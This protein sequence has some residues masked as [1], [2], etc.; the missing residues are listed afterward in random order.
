MKKN[1]LFLWII[2]VVNINLLLRAEEIRTFTLNDCLEFALK[3]SP[4]LRLAQADANIASAERK[5]VE[6][7]RYPQLNLLSE[8][9]HYSYSSGPQ[10]IEIIPALPV[11]PEA[12]IRLYRMGSDNT[13]VGL[14]LGK[15]IFDGGML[16]ARIAYASNKEK[17][18]TFSLQSIQL[19]IVYKVK[20]AFYNV[21]KAKALLKVA[22]KFKQNGKK[23]YDMIETLYQQGIVPQTDIEN[24]KTNLNEAELKLLT[25]KNSLQQALNS[26][27]LIMGM[28]LSTPLDILVPEV[29]SILPL[30]LT[31]EEECI[32]RAFENRPKIKEAE[33]SIKQAELGIKLAEA[34]KFPQISANTGYVVHS[35][36][37]GGL[38]KFY[39]RLNFS[40]PL[41]DGGES[42]AQIQKSKSLLET[43]KIQLD[44]LKTQISMEVITSF[45]EVKLKQD[46]FFLYKEKLALA[47]ENLKIKQEKYKN[48]LSDIKDLEDAELALAQA[49]TEFNNSFYD[50]QIAIAKLEESIGGKIEVK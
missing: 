3:N 17:E 5:I 11:P 18:K 23:N 33:V 24:Y 14:N 2:F 39:F 40:L 50:Y 21:A 37:S 29:T 4:E 22:E 28:D 42:K 15:T 45:R 46:S 38:E 49:E 12:R 13:Q 25:A 35:K 8:W 48:G 47:K 30:E 7:K 19:E 6:A 9:F 1:L 10:E 31:T 41:F 16:R 36:D 34:V 20:E 44:R 27:K 43:A 32:K 26:L